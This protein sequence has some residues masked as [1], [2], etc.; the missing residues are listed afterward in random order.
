MNTLLVSNKAED[1]A[2]LTRA[3]LGVAKLE[4]GNSSIVWSASILLS[5]WGFLDINNLF[6]HS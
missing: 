6:S 1:K 5:S 3:H 4:I 2:A